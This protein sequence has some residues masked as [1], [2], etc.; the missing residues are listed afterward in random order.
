MFPPNEFGDGDLVAV[1]F[2]LQPTQNVG[3]LRAEFA[4]VD[5]VTPQF[6]DGAFGLRVAFVV[7]QEGGDFGLT[8]GHEHDVF[9][10]FFKRETDGVV[11]RGVAG[12]QGGDYV[13]WGGEFGRGDRLGNGEIEER[14]VVET[15][16]GGERTRAFDERCTRLDAVDVMRN[17]ERF[18]EQV[19]KDETEIRF[20]RAVIYEIDAA[21]LRDH[22][23]D[24]RLDELREVIDLLLLPARILIHLAVDGQ[25]MQCLEQ[26]DGLT[27]ADVECWCGGG[28]FLWF[29]QNGD[30]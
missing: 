9:R 13:N 29:G 17:R 3:D 7:T 15:E 8:A 30:R 25:D 28:L 22:L 21:S 11:G 5:R 1:G 26:F 10:A 16:L 14:H 6:G 18:E 4:G 23:R 27:G 19:V 12:M 20:A 2:E 24:E